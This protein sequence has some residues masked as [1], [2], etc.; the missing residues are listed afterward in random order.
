MKVEEQD[1]RFYTALELIAVL[2]LEGFLFPL[3]NFSLIYPTIE[4]GSYVPAI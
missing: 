1:S 3:N 2:L 4:L